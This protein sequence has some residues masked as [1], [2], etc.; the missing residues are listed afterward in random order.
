MNIPLPYLQAL[1]VFGDSQNMTQAALRLGLTQSALS[2]Q[3]Q[4]LEKLLPQKALAAEGRKKILT[5]Y[6]RTL[7]D[8][9]REKLEGLSEIVTQA[10]QKWLSEEDSLFRLGAGKD[11][12]DSYGE[13]ISFKGRLHLTEGDSA[14]LENALSHR[15]LEAAVLPNPLNHADFASRLLFKESY[16]LLIPKKLIKD[17]PTF[18]ETTLKRLSNLSRLEEKT[19]GL[20]T[21]LLHEYGVTRATPP[22][23]VFCHWPT[24]VS[25]AQQ[26]AGWTLVPAT[27]ASSEKNLHSVS[28][29]AQ[30]LP[31]PSF[32][33]V[34]RKNLTS[35][36]WMKSFMQDLAL[37]LKNRGEE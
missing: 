31:A 27:F 22:K 37:S 6:G 2:K 10:G 24:L 11:L 20:A 18:S 8:D 33:L 28:V 1:V 3:L 15:R 34:Y 7:T 30:A 36:P 35:S 9:L 26:G 25:W 17:K 19:P 5:P 29:P 23:R 13:T 32:Y 12:L 14:F 21:R 16:R 4:S